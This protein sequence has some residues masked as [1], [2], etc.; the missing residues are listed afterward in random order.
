MNMNQLPA[1]L[2]KWNNPAS[3]FNADIDILVEC[4]LPAHV[5]QKLPQ[6]GIKAWERDLLASCMIGGTS[7][8][9]GNQPGNK[10]G[11][12]IEK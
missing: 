2:K 3:D 4:V 5:V 7:C 1:P 8:F 10:G 11:Y 6:D 12:K 9:H